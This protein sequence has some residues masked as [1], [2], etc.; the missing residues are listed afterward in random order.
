MSVEDQLEAWVREAIELRFTPIDT[1]TETVEEIIDQLTAVRTCSDRVEE[2][3]S[4]VR[5][6]KGR[7][8]RQ[9][10]DAQFDA[11]IKRDE[12]YQMNAA[13]RVASFVTADEKRADASLAS[14]QEKRAA[15]KAKRLADLADETYRCIE[16]ARWGLSAI[17]QDL[18]A[19]LHAKQVVSSLE[20]S[21]RQ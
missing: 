21:G 2:I 1:G 18:R 16:D 13:T 9:L 6:L 17:R 14:I 19:I 15:H 12:A 4:Q 5:R 7:L 11:E 10:M 3:Q 8:G 20:Y